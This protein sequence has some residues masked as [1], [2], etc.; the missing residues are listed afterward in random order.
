MTRDLSDGKQGGGSKKDG[1]H[2][3]GNVKKTKTK[4]Y[5][6]RGIDVP[7]VRTGGN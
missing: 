2:S 4:H 7:T 3:R 5:K 1:E 6:R